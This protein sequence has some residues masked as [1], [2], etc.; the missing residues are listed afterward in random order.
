MFTSKRGQYAPPA[1]QPYPQQRPYQPNI[2]QPGAFG[3]PAQ[4]PTVSI[5]PKTLLLIGGVALLI[6]LTFTVIL[7]IRANQ[8]HCP[9][10]LKK[11]PCDLSVSCGPETNYE[12]V[13]TPIEGGAEGC[14]LAMAKTACVG[15]AGPLTKWYDD[16]SEECVTDVD[17][18][19][20]ITAYTS[21]QRSTNGGGK[22]RITPVMNIP[23]NLNKDEATIE[24]VAE[25]LI[26][27]NMKITHMELDG[28]DAQRNVL[29]LGELNPD[30]P[31]AAVQSPVKLYLRLNVPG[32]DPSGSLKNMQLIIDISYTT[33]SGT[34]ISQKSDRISINLQSLQFSWLRPTRAYPC[35]IAKQCDDNDPSTLDYCDPQDAPF[36]KHEAKAG[37]CGN[38][39]CES[40]ENKCTCAAD[41]GACGGVG[42]VTTSQCANNQC[43]VQLRDGVIVQPIRIVNPNK[44]GKVSVTTTIEYNSPFDAT[45]DQVHVSIS[46][47][48]RDAAVDSFSIDKVQLFAGQSLELASKSGGGDLAAGNSFTATF[49]LSTK[50]VEEELSPQLKVSYSLAAGTQNDHSSFTQTLQKFSIYSP[51]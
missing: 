15:K 40:N 47:D 21:T 27:A 6:I 14:K 5:P 25:Q 20:K 10:D 51:G 8:P 37:A 29:V 44:L 16:K 7:I 23:F 9:P 48:T 34:S 46:V 22:Y 3:A 39:I 19:T 50:L 42:K 41:C 49:P 35:P 13:R 36:C 2:P 26:G 17:P 43:V 38:G 31:I 32:S 45:Q 4:Q 18:T 11:T 33:G 12:V 28:T 30:R 1:G 24:F